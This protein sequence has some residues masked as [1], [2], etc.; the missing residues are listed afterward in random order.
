MGAKVARL[1][2]SCGITLEACDCVPSSWHQFLALLGRWGDLQL[3][4]WPQNGTSL[5][6]SLGEKT[7]LSDCQRHC[8]Q[9]ARR[10]QLNVVEPTTSLAT[11]H[12]RCVCPACVLLRLF[13]HSAHFGKHN[14]RMPS[15]SS[16]CA[17]HCQL[18]LY[19]LPASVIYVPLSLSHSLSLYL[20]LK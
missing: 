14:H 11:E 6:L 5:S 19:S 20:S 8:G 17:P 18:T 9:Q 4:I 2:L 15:R 13:W 12:C 1:S 7:L 10:Y 3:Q 16:T